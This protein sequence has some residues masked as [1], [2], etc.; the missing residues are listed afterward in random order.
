MRR[1]GATTLGAGTAYYGGTQYAG[2]PVQK[3]QAVVP[4]AVGALLAAGAA[5]SLGWSLREYEVIG[6]DAPAEGLNR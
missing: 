4:L 1:I 2:S 5:V 3:A 6:S